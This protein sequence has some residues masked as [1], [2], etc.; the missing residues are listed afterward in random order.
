MRQPKKVHRKREVQIEVVEEQFNLYV[1]LS[2][3]RAA[4]EIDKQQDVE[5]EDDFVDPE[6]VKIC[7]PYAFYSEETIITKKTEIKTYEEII[8]YRQ[9]LDEQKEQKLKNQ[10]EKQLAAAEQDQ[11]MQSTT[12]A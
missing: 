6:P 7:N 5:M 4:V 3:L 9:Y 12:E 1:N 8:T 2:A 11:E 10:Q